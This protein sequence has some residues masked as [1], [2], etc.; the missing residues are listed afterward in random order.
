GRYGQRFRGEARELARVLLTVAEWPLAAV[1][2]KALA[3]ALVRLSER[4]ELPGGI[5][6][7]ASDAELVELDL[8][9]GDEDRDRD[10]DPAVPGDIPGV[11]GAAAH[12]AS[13]VVVGNGGGGL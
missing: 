5:D 9:R 4:R 13:T 1:A 12:P 3:R 7:Q 8:G 6:V 10:A 11:Q 2:V